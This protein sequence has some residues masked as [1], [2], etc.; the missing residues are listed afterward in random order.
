MD[1]ALVEATGGKLCPGHIFQIEPEH[2]DVFGGCLLIA[3]EIHKWGVC[4]YF[5]IPG[6]GQAFYRCD[7]EYMELVGY[8][9]WHATEDE[10]D[11]AKE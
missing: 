6:H 9:I 1:R 3:T 2:D 8:A 11:T 10:E 7:Y 4:G 5:D